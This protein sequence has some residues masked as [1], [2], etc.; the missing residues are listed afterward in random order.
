MPLVD[1]AVFIPGAGHLYVAPPG[2]AVPASL[3]NP[4]SPWNN[5]G[6]S[7][8][9]DGVTLGKEGGDSETLGTWQNPA[10]RVRRDPTTWFL[11]MNLHQFSNDT[12][13]FF[14]GGG[15]IAT[16]GKFGVPIT[17]VAQERALFMR[18]VDGTA[19]APLYIPRVSLLAEDDIELDVEQ[20]VSFPIRASMLGITGSNL[21]EF[22]ITG[23]GGQVN[24]VQTIT[25]TG[26]PTGGT[27]TLTYNGQ[28]TAAIAYNAA[29]SAVQAALI[30][31]NNIG[32]SDVVC[33][34]GPHPGTAVI[35][36][37]G[38]DLAAQDI[39]Q[40]TASSAS[41]TGGTT[42]TVTVTT[43]TPGG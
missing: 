20:F 6:H 37:F 11:T 36:T 24:E 32:T 15:D 30:A 14:F 38:G 4:A 26:T 39:A 9:E 40:M 18:I 42:P 21:M 2:T 25:I 33:T 31:L 5:L 28:T 3:T 16:V 41:L 22:Y 27:Y 17:P 13:K 1:S 43:T 10:L 7:S 34:G 8:V 12:L 29:A 35:A 23:L 19:E